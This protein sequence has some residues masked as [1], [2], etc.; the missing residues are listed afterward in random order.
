MTTT[1]AIRPS[2][3]L[4]L[5]VDAMVANFVHD[6][7]LTRR[8]SKTL[9]SNGFTV[10]SLRSHGYTQTAEPTLCSRSSTAAPRSS[11]DPAPAEGAEALRKEA[12]RRAEAREFFGHISFVS[13][14]VRKQSEEDP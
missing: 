10:K 2:D 1:V 6:P 4:Q 5:L 3:P 13:V 11:P 12:R 8:L 7:W 9:E 14:I